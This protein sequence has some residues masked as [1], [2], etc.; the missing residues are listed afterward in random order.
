MLTEKFTWV[1][2]LVYPSKSFPI[3]SLFKVGVLGSFGAMSLWRHHLLVRF[4]TWPSL[5]NQ[6]SFIDVRIRNRGI[7]APGLDVVLVQ[8]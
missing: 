4:E 5:S 2:H 7:F 8:A 3:S 1:R 6:M